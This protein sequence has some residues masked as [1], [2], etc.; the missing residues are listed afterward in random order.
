MVNGLIGVEVVCYILDI[1][2]LMNVLVYEI[3]G[4]LSDYYDF[5]KKVVFFFEVNFCG[6]F[7]VGVVVVVYEV[8]YVI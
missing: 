4:I 1:N 6:C 2:G 8:G 7:I 5:W 3:K